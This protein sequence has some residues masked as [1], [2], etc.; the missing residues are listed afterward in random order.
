MT[1]IEKNVASLTMRGY[2]QAKIAKELGVS[3]EYIRQISNKLVKKGVIEHTKKYKKIS[4]NN[5]SKNITDQIR[6]FEKVNMNGDCWLWTGS[7]MPT[8]YG[9]FRSE[10][11]SYAHRYSLSL[12]EKLD[13]KLHIDHICR[14][15]SCVNPNHLQQVTCQIN[16]LRSPIRNPKE[17]KKYYA[18]VS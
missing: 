7:K 1:S 12:V 8:G 2:Y 10:V 5:L 9:H 3:R 11:S 15:V 14:V 13:P 6:F 16:V 17:Y 4:Y 18:R